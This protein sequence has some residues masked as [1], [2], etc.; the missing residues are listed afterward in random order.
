MPLHRPP[1]RHLEELVVR[2]AALAGRSLGEIA[3]ALDVSLAGTAVRTKGRVGQLLERALGASAGSAA[4]P[5]FPHLGVELKTVPVDA[6]GAPREST[7]VCTIDLATADRTSWE[8][9]LARRKLAHVL[10]VPVFVEHPEVGAR[11]VGRG[12][13]FRPTAAQE[14]VLRA[15]F[16][17]AMGAIGA[18]GADDLTAH[19]GRW[20]QVR[21][22][23]ANGA[24]R[25]F[26]PDDDG[27]L[28]ETGP[29]GFYLRRKFVAAVLLDPA[30]L[31]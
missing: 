22:K 3:A 15:D 28:V 6:A 17:D 20:L 25:T 19:H 14:A 29:R 2:V 30:A 13:F 11:R 21:P 31:P 26:A 18:G 12:C 8:E 7:F 5:D 27:A 4:L 1:P 10:F 16:D 23:A 9:S 24:V